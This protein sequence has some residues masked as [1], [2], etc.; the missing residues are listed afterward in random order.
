MGSVVGRIANRTAKGTFAVNGTEYHLAI[1][2]GPNNLHSGPDYYDTRLWEAREEAD[3][4]S[5]TFS[6]TSPDGDQG[7]PGEVRISVT[8][9]LTEDDTLLLTYRVTADQDTPVSLTNHGYFNL[10]GQAGGTILSHELRL[11]ADFYT[12]ASA[13]S[14]PTGEI[15]SVEGT[16]MDFREFKVIG[17]EINA[18]F[19]QLQFAGGYDHNWCLNHGAGVYG[20][21]AQVRNPEN[22]RCMDVYT[23][24]PGLQVYTANGL[25]DTAGKNGTIY[26]RREAYCFEAQNYPNAVNQPHFPSPIVKKGQEVVSRTGYRFYTR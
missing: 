1:N 9:T 12:P 5:V 18:D 11:L 8:Y 24:C 26:D 16:P 13:D 17:R 3:G 4:Q 22:G 14:I 20:L 6:L 23:D 15:R 10:A 2:N 19:P 7:F 25:C 21:A